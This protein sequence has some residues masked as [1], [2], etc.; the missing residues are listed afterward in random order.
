MIESL[1]QQMVPE[2]FKSDSRYREGHLRVINALPRRRVLGVHVPQMKGFVRSLTAEQVREYIAAFEQ[3]PPHALCYEE[4]VIWG[5]LINR[6]ACSLE[7]RL[8]LLDRYIPLLDNWAVCDTSCS[9]AKWAARADKE[10][11]WLWLQKWYGSTREFEVRFAVVFSMVCFLQPLWV[12]RVFSRIDAIDFGVIKSQYK[13]IKGRPENVQEGS[14]QG[15]EP[16]Y[17]RMAVAWLLATSL[18]RF[19]QL[20]R[21][22]VAASHLPADVI[23]LYVRKARESFRTRDVSAL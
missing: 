18:A 7:E 16:Y 13:S 6:C 3:E 5:L 22:Y 4:T 23:K 12:E 14:V 11:L 21:H 20:T 10:A 2:R 9:A 15:S 1:L 17:V 19:P 8:T